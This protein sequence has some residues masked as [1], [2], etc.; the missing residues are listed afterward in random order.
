MTLPMKYSW[1]VFM[2]IDRAGF[3]VYRYAY[4]Y[5]TICNVMHD[6]NGV[7]SSLELK[8]ITNRTISHGISLTANWQY[9]IYICAVVKGMC[10]T[11]SERT[12]EIL[13]LVFLGFS[14][15]QIP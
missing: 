3:M 13:D 11:Y 8:Y 7:L 4:I 15:V 14:S 5:I 6:F 9:L 12:F 1:N 10:P 2:A